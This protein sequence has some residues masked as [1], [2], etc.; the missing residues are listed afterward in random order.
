MADLRL[1]QT[2]YVYDKTSKN[3]IE[4]KIKIILPKYYGIKCLAIVSPSGNPL[5]ITPPFGLMECP[6]E[7]C[8]A[9]IASSVNHRNDEEWKIMEEY[10]E[11]IY[12]LESLL[13]FPL[14]HCVSHGGKYTDTLAAKVYRRMV[15]EYL[16]KYQDAD[17]KSTL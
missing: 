4:G 15:E 6:K 3:Y 5:M 12:D 9:D 1:G 7:E 8:F 11:E 17:H 14:R 10:K 2:V 16:A 13:T